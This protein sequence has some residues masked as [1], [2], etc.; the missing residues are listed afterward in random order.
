MVAAST[1]SCCYRMYSFSSMLWSTWHLSISD[2]AS[3]VTA[4]ACP[5]S[6]FRC[7]AALTIHDESYSRPF[8]ALLLP[9]ARSFGPAVV[10][11]VFTDQWIFWVGPFSGAI[12]AALLYELFFRPSGPI[13]SAASF[14]LL[15]GC[16]EALWPQHRCMFED[17]QTD[18]PVPQ[19]V[20]IFQHTS[21]PTV[22]C[23]DMPR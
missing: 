9:A 20:V 6:L 19:S 2:R 12:I 16:A 13:V 18:P 5:C 4:L 10:S 22:F 7:P 21:M 8:L 15:P 17:E 23:I 11:G 1:V 14:Q 3:S